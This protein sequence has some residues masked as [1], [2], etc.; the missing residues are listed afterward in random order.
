MNFSDGTPYELKGSCT[1]WVGGKDGDYIKVLPID[2]RRDAFH[3]PHGQ[4][5]RPG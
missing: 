2:I 4:R 1:V 5:N 3:E